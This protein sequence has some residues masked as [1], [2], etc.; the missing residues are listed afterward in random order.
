MGKSA[1]RGIFQVAFHVTGQLSANLDIKWKA[2]CN[3]TLIHVSAVQSDADACGVEVGDSTD[4]DGYITKFSCGISGT[5][6]EKQA[7]TDFDG[8]LADSQ[9]PDIDDG[10]IIAIAVDFDYNAGEG[11]G[12]ASDVT[13]VLTFAE[14]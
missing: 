10:D 1:A 14:G 7:I 2:P 3:L 13:L 11:S 6:V 12:A 9:Y 8:D 5:P 4:A